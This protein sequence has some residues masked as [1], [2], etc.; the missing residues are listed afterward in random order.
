MKPELNDFIV[1]IVSLGII[2]LGS[3]VHATNQLRIAREKK[4]PFT[5]ADFYILLPISAFAGIIFGLTVLL[6]TEN[7]YLIMLSSGIGSFLGIAGLN[8]VAQSLLLFLVSK[9]ENTK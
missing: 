9:I 5:K 8:K 6:F 1:L 3:I 4:V 2:L 7:P